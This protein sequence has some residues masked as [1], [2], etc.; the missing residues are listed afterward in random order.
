MF[1]P[2]LNQWKLQQL[3]SYLSSVTKKSMH[4][5]LEMSFEHRCKD[6]SL[7]AHTVLTMYHLLALPTEDFMPP[8]LL[9]WERERGNS[10]S[11]TQRKKYT[12]MCNVRAAF[13]VQEV[14]DD[15]GWCLNNDVRLL[16]VKK[17]GEDIVMTSVLKSLRPNRVLWLFNLHIMYKA[18]T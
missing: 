5:D 4:F 12:W 18:S 16:Q 2:P 1:N 6:S 8:F 13:L 11:H 7:S 10:F 17:E 9:K 3:Y 15:Y 14:N